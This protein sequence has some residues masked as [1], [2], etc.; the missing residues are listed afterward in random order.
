LIKKGRD[1]ILVRHG[2][3]IIS[4]LLLCSIILVS[5]LP[6]YAQEEIK[7]PAEIVATIDAPDN[8]IPPIGISEWTTINLNV[9]DAY[10]IPWA[11]L[12]SELPI[13]AKYIWPII[14]PS[15]KPLLGY[16]SLR[17]EPEIIEGDSRG[18]YTRV[19]PSAIPSADQ[20]RNYSLKLEVKTDDIAV[21][22]AVVV[23]IKVTRVNVFGD[24]AGV[25][26][27]YIPVKASSLNNIK[28]ETQVSTK[29]TAPHSY[30]HFDIIVRN[31]G[32][33]RDM[34]SLEFIEE[35]GLEV[36]TSKQLFV[37][38]PGESQDIRI[39]ILTSEKLFDTGTPNKIEIYA[40]SSGD[41]NS[42]HIG[43]IVVI[44]RGVFI[45]PLVGIIAT[46]IIVVLI[47]LCILFYYI[48]N[49]RDQELFGKPTK[50]WTL[51]EE[52]KY[53]DKLKEKD[54]EEYDKVLQMMK[55]EYQS[56]LLWFEDY[57]NSMKSGEKGSLGNKFTNFF[58]GFNEKSEEDKS[59]K[60][61]EKIIEE[62]KDIEKDK[63]PKVESP[64][65]TAD[66][67]RK[68]KVLLKIKRKQEKQK[69]KNKG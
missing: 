26:Y 23:G 51:P 27:I 5:S 29:E 7:E 59:I 32:Y 20:G 64:K 47:I 31:L 14:H 36:A 19:T 67:R 13:L 58:K 24:D 66:Q 4:M 25:S 6:V 45:S 3:K 1:E 69:L 40:V 68:E 15:W 8:I 54:K 17:F 22:Y 43:T 53:L 21:D 63:A 52:K 38:N 50:P 62:T 35:N 39:D 30:V 44:T 28:M 56:A 41:S 16:S 49:K 60:K 12:L 46:P 61:E 11:Y 10:G 34:F 65:K 33:Y 55:D 9:L 57:R 2:T 37:L 48:K 18:W 42:M